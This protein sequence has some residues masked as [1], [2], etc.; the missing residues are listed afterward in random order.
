MFTQNGVSKLKEK[1]IRSSKTWQPNSRNISLTDCHPFQVEP[2]ASDCFQPKHEHRWSPVFPCTSIK[3]IYVPPVRSIDWSVVLQT[4]YMC[5]R[6]GVQ[7]HHHDLRAGHNNNHLVLVWFSLFLVREFLFSP[8]LQEDGVVR[9]FEWG[10][11]FGH[12]LFVLRRIRGPPLQRSP[13]SLLQWLKQENL[14]HEPRSS[15]R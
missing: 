5:N 12:K 14:E 7:R 15:F 6:R 4:K 13:G 2:T 11:V 10:Y 1:E 3:L 8:P 9:W